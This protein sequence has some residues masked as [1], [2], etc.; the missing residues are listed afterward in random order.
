[1]PWSLQSARNCAQRNEKTAILG[2]SLLY[3]LWTPAPVMSPSI[4][5][6]GLPASVEPVWKHLHIHTQRFTFYV[7]LSPVKSG[8]IWGDIS[9]ILMAGKEPMVL[10]IEQE[11]TLCTVGWHNILSKTGNQHTFFYLSSPFPYDQA[12]PILMPNF[13]G[14][15]Q[16]SGC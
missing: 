16:A 2:T 1:M 15:I 14:H 8:S 6:V 12:N 7:L 11:T 3:L 4:S 10:C 9:I 5:M 13:P